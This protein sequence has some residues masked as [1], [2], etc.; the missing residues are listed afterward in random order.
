MSCTSE[1]EDSKSKTEVV[2]PPPMTELSNLEKGTLVVGATFASLSVKLR[3]AMSQGGVP[4]AVEYCNSAALP[5]VDSLSKEYNAKIRRTSLKIR[6]PANDPTEAEQE[7][8]NNYARMALANQQ[9]SP[10]LIENEKGDSVFYAP[11]KVGALCLKC[12]GIPGKTLAM[13]DLATIHSFYPGDA[14]IGYKEGD[15]R[16]IWSIELLE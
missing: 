4:N 2:T 16:G 6:N 14:A 11:I 1:N 8:L 9:L 15:F 5:I 3:Q 10:M 7:V 13:E 12:H